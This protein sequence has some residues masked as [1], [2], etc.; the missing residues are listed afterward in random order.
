MR[1]NSEEHILEYWATRLRHWGL[2]EIA[3]ALLEATGALNLI[4]AQLVY[5]GQPMMRGIVP[6]EHLETLAG[7]LENEHKTHTFVNLLREVQA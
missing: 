1:P 4:G 2:N 7:V 5:L 3:A 6:N